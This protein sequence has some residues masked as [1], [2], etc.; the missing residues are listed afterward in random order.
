MLTASHASVPQRENKKSGVD[1]AS[2]IHD[3]AA[4]KTE[5]QPFARP[6]PGSAFPFVY[7]F[8]CSSSSS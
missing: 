8:A 2:S 7:A 5:L 6:P 3:I 4:A 1:E